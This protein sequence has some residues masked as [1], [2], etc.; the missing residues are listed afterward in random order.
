MVDFVA[1]A[2]AEGHGKIHGVTH[3]GFTEDQMRSMFEGAGV[4]KNFKF[5]AMKEDV[6]FEKAHGDKDMV[7]RVFFARGEKEAT[8]SQI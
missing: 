6:V 3:H 1:H 2:A 5:D 7:R 4:G 8:G